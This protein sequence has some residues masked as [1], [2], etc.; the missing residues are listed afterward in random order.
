M[1]P[2][3]RLYA[4]ILLSSARRPSFGTSDQWPPMAR[5]I[6]PSCARR[7]RP[8]SL[9]SPGAAANTSV[10][11]AGSRVSR[12]RGSIAISTSS[13]VP[14]PTKPDID[15][16][17]PFRMMAAASAEEMILF[18]MAVSLS[19]G[20]PCGDTGRKQR[21]GPA[22]DE[23]PDMTARQRQLGVVLGADLVPQCA[24][25]RRR[26]DVVVLGV[27]V[28]DRHGDVAQNDTPAAD[29]QLVLDQL[30]L[31]VEVFQP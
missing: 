26:N 5:L 17:S 18:R 19:L 2:S 8:R 29:L 16:V 21:L 13:G 12:K 9:P 4:S 10:R 31:L 23:N 20:Q 25:C 22:A 11:P 1:Q 7:L 27:D 24:R 15:T 14:M 6:N 28:Q 3:G 30:V